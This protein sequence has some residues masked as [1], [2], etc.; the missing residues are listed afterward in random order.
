MPSKGDNR[1]KKGADA[2]TIALAHLETVGYSLLCRNFRT[3]YGEIDLIMV[4]EGSGGLIFIE[5]K[6]GVKS[7]FPGYLEA[8]NEKKYRKIAQVAAEFIENQ[9]REYP[10]YR[11][12]AVFV[13][14][15]LA[16][17]VFHIKNV[18]YLA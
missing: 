5:V 14:R 9:D 13:E 11:V 4:E 2:E 3:M 1:R 8:V 18:Y 10:L 12:D 7:V 6:S 17:Q 15:G 16:K